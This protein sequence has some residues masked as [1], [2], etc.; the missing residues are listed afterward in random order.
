MVARFIFHILNDA[1]SNLEWI[2][3]HG[4]RLLLLRL[5]HVEQIMVCQIRRGGDPYNP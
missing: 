5:E 4:T 2:D 3:T 1:S